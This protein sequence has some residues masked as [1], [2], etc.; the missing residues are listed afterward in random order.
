MGL[1]GLYGLMGNLLDLYMSGPEAVDADC[2]SSSGQISSFQVC[3]S[4]MIP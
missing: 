4:L 1:T 2:F 3:Y